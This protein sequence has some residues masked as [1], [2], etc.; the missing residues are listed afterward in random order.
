MNLQAR[1]GIKVAVTGASGYIAGHVVKQLI[2][3]GYSV[4]GSV[5]SLA[6]THKLSHLRQLFPSLELFE[7]DL[8][9]EGSFDEAFQDV[10]CVMHTASPV[11]LFP[12]DPQ[13]ELI[14]PALNGTLNVLRAAAK[15]PSVQR[16]IFTSSLAAIVPLVPTAGKVYNEDD[17]NLQSTISEAPYHHSK[18]LAEETAWKFVK[19][20]NDKREKQ[21]NTNKLELVAIN[22]SWVLGPP[23]SARLEASSVPL[24]LKLVTQC[25]ESGVPGQ[26]YTCVDVRDV[27]RAHVLG[28][29]RADANGKRFVLSGEEA[30]SLLELMHFLRKN[31]EFRNYW[32][33]IPDKESGPVPHRRRMSNQR[34]RKELGIVF[35]PIEKS[36]ADML[37]A[38]IEIGILPRK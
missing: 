27:A 14:E 38:M 15:A 17:W 4:K 21:G 12:K 16:V 2:E 20:E 33:D 28:M 22:P 6:D 23:L 30:V 37:R 24:V 36:L 13:T 25:K 34:A 31:E 32:D 19:E 11:I 35:T 26:A 9:K 8:L 29:E 5:R 3:A 10:H 18:R 7:A 1:S